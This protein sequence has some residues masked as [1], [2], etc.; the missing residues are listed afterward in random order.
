MDTRTLKRLCDNSKLFLGI[1]KCNIEYMDQSCWIRLCEQAT[2]RVLTVLEKNTDKLGDD[3]WLTLCYYLVAKSGGR[4]RGDN[5]GFI[6][7]FDFIENNADLLPK[8]CFRKL[9]EM[10]GHTRIYNLIQ[11][12]DE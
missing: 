5:Q 12:F 2:P 8:Q 10:G 3:C 6:R 4:F 9:R 7:L 11:L 1:I